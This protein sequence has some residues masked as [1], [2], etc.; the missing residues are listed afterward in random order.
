[1]T[2]EATSHKVSASDVSGAL[3]A[4]TVGGA[5]GHGIPLHS[6]SN[7]VPTAFEGPN[8]VVKK[9]RKVGQTCWRRKYDLAT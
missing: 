7:M 3:P 4:E 5:D 8:A 9:V 1:M 6:S 2:R